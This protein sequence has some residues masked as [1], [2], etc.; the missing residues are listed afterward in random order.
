MTPR[1][2]GDPDVFLNVPY[3]PRFLDIFLAYIAGISALGL[4][5]RTTLEIPGGERR[6]DRILDLIG[7]CRSSVH[8]LSLL[9]PHASHR[10]VPH[11]KMAFEL[12]LTVAWDRA[13]PGCHTWYAFET[14]ARRVGSTLS[15]LSGTDLYIHGG[16]PAGV[17]RELCNAFVRTGSQPD[18]RTMKRLYAELKGGLPDILRAAGT[19]SVF[20]ARVDG[21]LRIVARAMRTELTHPGLG[22]PSADE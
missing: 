17:F 10:Q 12:G 5:P 16:R 18:V 6:L 15:D 1:A 21:H 2:A 7:S 3:D 9:A 4:Y 22:Q 13:H 11:F 20:A 8:D 19:R 14:N